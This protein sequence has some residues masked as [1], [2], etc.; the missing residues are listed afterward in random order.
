MFDTIYQYLAYTDDY[1]ILNECVGYIEIFE[2][3]RANILPFKD[4]AFNQLKKIISYLTS[5]I[6]EDICH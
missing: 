1:S 3:N 4:S 6:D 5:N 2:N